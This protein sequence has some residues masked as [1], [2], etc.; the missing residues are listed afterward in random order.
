MLLL[1]VVVEVVPHSPQLEAV[2]RKMQQEAEVHGQRLEVEE[3]P[4]EAHERQA[5][6][7]ESTAGQA[8]ASKTQANLRRSCWS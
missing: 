7:A 8:S 6:L 5:G 1:G 2:V 3:V 4:Q